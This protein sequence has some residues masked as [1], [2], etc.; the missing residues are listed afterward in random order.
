MVYPTSKLNE[1]VTKR[2]SGPDEHTPNETPETQ[3]AYYIYILA[4]GGELSEFSAE[5]A[6]C[7]PVF[8]TICFAC[9]LIHEKHVYM[10]SANRCFIE[11]KTLPGCVE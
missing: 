11:P 4:D 6:D 3:V 1:P 7:S 5:L 8:G 10:S 2:I 9:R